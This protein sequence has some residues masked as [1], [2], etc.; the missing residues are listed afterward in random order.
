L[1]RGAAALNAQLNLDSPE[2]RAAL[3][4]RLDDADDDT[5]GEAMIGMARRKD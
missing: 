2:I 3:I 5:R 1:A 4:A